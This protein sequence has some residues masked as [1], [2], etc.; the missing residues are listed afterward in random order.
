MV[1]PARLVATIVMAW[2]LVLARP[3]VAQQGDNANALNAQALK[4][5]GEGKYAEAIPLAQRALAI[6]ES[7]LGPDHPYV[8]SFLDNLAALYIAEGRYAEAEPLF[9]RAP[10][11]DVVMGPLEIR[12]WRALFRHP[13]RRRPIRV[14]L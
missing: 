6:G 12:G 8:G 14:P 13:L 9:K 11:V 2:G 10:F 5:Y 4:L 1:S 3:A 7:T